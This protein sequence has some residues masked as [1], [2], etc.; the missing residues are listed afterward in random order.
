MMKIKKLK[1]PL[2]VEAKYYRDNRQFA[3]ALATLHRLS[4]KYPDHVSLLYLL[5]ST[6]YESGNENEAIVYCNKAIEKDNLCKEAYELK[7]ILLKRKGDYAESEKNLLHTLE[8]DPD[9]HQARKH[10]IGLYYFYLKEYEKSEEHCVYM[11]RH[12]DPDRDSMPK[13]KKAK[14]LDWILLI[15]NMYLSTLIQLKKYREGAELWEN[16]MAF[17]LSLTDDPSIYLSEHSKMYLLYYIAGDEENRKKKYGYLRE[18]YG[19][20]EAEIK[21][22]EIDVDKNGIPVM[23]KEPN[24]IYTEE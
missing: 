23:T 19:I 22:D 8:L 14:V 20:S 24:I 12:R 15:S 9:M 16:L 13:R 5:A 11:L 17:S 4:A 6:Y 7:G 3:E 21:E 10:L 1:D 18:F 2:L